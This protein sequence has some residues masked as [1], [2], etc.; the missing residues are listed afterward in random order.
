MPNHVA[1]FFLDFRFYFS[2]SFSF[3]FCDI[4]VLVS[5]I[6]LVIVS[7]FLRQ[8]LSRPKSVKKI[9]AQKQPPGLT[10][11]AGQEND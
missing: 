2:F 6:V 8:H 1:V 11:N 9:G 4:L 10:E 3:C 7:Q 5:V